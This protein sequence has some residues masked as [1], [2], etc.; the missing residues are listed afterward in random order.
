MNNTFTLQQMMTIG[1]QASRLFQED[2]FS[3]MM[4]SDHLLLCCLLWAEVPLS[5]KDLALRLNLSPARL[6]SLLKTLETRQLIE[7]RQD[8]HDKRKYWISLS[9]E[10]RT[11][12]SSLMESVKSAA[13]DFLSRLSSTE[14]TLLISL[15]ERIFA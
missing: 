2:E 9:S 11:L 7:R 12:I 15:L 3:W 8:D 1:F 5:P 13:A 6:S 14:T 10:G 4:K